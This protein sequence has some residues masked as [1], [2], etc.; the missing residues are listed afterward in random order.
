V[1]GVATATA[2]LEPQLDQFGARAMVLT[3]LFLLVVIVLGIVAAAATK[4]AT[5]RVQRSTTINTPP[6][7]IFPLINDF[8]NFGRWSPWEHL[9]PQMQ[10]TI[11][12]PPSGVGAVY[13]WSGNSKAGAGRMEI[14]ESTPSSRLVMKLD[15]LK[16]FE[17]HNTA[18]YTLQR[19]GDAT[20]VTWAMYGPSPFASKVMQ[21]FIS[22]DTMLGRDF[23]KGLTQM[24]AAAEQ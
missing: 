3:L 8:Q 17:A 4:P 19:E 23:E 22:M 5:F 6:E 7:R 1:N 18:E 11:T 24:K 10:R 14:L 20:R 15:F 16:P 13:A 9:D 21:V 12:G 2:A